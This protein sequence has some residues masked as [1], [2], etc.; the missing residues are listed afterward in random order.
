MSLSRRAMFGGL[1]TLA[2]PAIIRTPGLLM[3][4][5]PHRSYLMR[6]WDEFESSMEQDFGPIPPFMT[7]FI[8]PKLID[9]LC[10]QADTNWPMRTDILYS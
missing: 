3:A 6:L 10:K 5:G 2:A 9:I 8:D 1:I 7:T 4:I